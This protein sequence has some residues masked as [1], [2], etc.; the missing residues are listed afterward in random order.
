[1]TYF[2]LETTLSVRG[3]FYFLFLFPVFYFYGRLLS[4]LGSPSA[5]RGTTPRSRHR[6]G[7]ASRGD[8]EPGE[9]S[10]SLPKCPSLEFH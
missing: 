5:T 1:M 6:R 2:V 4:H 7:G 9:P 10:S 8:S 3:V